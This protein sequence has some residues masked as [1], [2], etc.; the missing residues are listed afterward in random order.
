MMERP[1]NS[2]RDRFGHPSATSIGE[3]PHLHFDEIFFTQLNPFCLDDTP[4]LS[5]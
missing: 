4:I 1:A 2:F 3:V 5:L